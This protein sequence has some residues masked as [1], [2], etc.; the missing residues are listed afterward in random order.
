MFQWFLAMM[1]RQSFTAGSL[2]LSP[3]LELSLLVLAS[4]VVHDVTRYVSKAS[5]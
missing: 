1:L 5:C 2:Q 4:R 3:F